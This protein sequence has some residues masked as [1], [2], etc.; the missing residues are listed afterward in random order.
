MNVTMLHLSFKNMPATPTIT[1]T[2]VFV[3]KGS[4]TAESVCGGRFYSTLRRR[5][6]LSDMP[7]KILKSDSKVET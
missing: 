3:L 6:L 5:Y 2:I 1:P 4:A 7:K